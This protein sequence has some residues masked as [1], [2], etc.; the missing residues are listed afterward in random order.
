GRTAKAAASRTPLKE[1]VGQTKGA[2]RRKS[3]PKKRKV[4]PSPAPPTDSWDDEEEAE[5]TPPE[6]SDSSFTMDPNAIE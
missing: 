4:L 6:D 5:L 3:A 1:P 2:A